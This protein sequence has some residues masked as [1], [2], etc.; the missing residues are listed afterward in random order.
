VYYNEDFETPITSSQKHEILARLPDLSP[1]R[2]KIVEFL[3]L[4]G[5]WNW[6]RNGSTNAAFIHDAARRYFQ[7][8][9]DTF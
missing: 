9:F 2:Q 4:Q 5:G 3:Y 8:F 1:E 7:R 6:G